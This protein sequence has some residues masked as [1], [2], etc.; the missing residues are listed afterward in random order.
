MSCWV[1]GEALTSDMMLQQCRPKT[2]LSIV[3]FVSTTADSPATSH[4]VL[5]QRGQMVD[6]HVSLPVLPLLLCVFVLGASSRSAAATGTIH[7]LPV[8]L[9]AL[10]D[11]CRFA[12]H[13]IGPDP[14]VMNTRKQGGVSYACTR[15]LPITAGLVGTAMDRQS[16]SSVLLL[17]CRWISHTMPDMP[18]LPVNC[19][20]ACWRGFYTRSIG[21]RSACNSIRGNVE[22]YSSAGV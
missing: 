5:N 1:L 21:G 6:P 12:R 9:E 13:V 15:R 17:V 14:V 4:S 16:C 7:A 8:V 3:N 22:D 2:S 11:R 19:L 18:A 20:L 10:S